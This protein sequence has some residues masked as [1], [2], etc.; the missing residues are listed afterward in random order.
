[1]SI[2][3]RNGS[4]PTATTEAPKKNTP[5]I[6]SSTKERIP[7]ISFL[8][9]RFKKDSTAVFVCGLTSG[10]RFP[11]QRLKRH[12]CFLHDDVLDGHIVAGA[13]VSRQKR[14]TKSVPRQALRARPNSFFCAPGEAQWLAR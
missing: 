13:C 6:Q 1:V 10:Q 2:G 9:G 12:R 5:R 8:W 7:P 3:G 4:Y 11:H 14:K